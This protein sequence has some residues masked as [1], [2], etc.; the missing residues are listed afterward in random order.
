VALHL[1]AA[2]H[3]QHSEPWRRKTLDLPETKFKE[4]KEK[5]KYGV[6]VKKAAGLK[7]LISY[8]ST[9]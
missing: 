8:S 1:P 2:L 9:Y 6:A 5:K 3:V 7:P 4:K